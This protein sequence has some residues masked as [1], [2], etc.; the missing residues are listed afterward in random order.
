M[1]NFAIRGNC[2]KF[3][4]QPATARV[5][6]LVDALDSKSCVLNRRAGS[7]PASGTREISQQTINLLADF[8]NSCFETYRP[9]II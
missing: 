9:Y 6:E 7:S 1:K 2:D 5:A 4:V 3:A 8:N